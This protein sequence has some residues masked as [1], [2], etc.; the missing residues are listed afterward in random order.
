MGPEMRTTLPASQ[1]EADPITTEVIRGG[2]R[3]AA[4]QMKRAIIRTAFS[5]IVRDLYDFAVAIFDREVRLLA[6]APTVAQFMGTLSFCVEEAVKAVGGEEALEPGDILLYNIPYGT[7]SHSPDAA[8][9]MPVFHSDQLIGYAATKAHW[10]DIGAKESYCTDTTSVFQ[11][12]ILFP[13]VKLYS[14]GELVQDVMRIALANSRFPG[15]VAGD[16]QAQIGGLRT[17]AAGLLRLVERYG[18][19]TFWPCVERMLDHSERLVRSYLEQIPDGRYVGQGV[20][21]NNGLDD[22]PI[23]FEVG[24]EISGS[25]VTV[26]YSNSPEAQRG[27]MNCPRP[28]TVSYTRVAIS[29]LAGGGIPPN[30]GTFR[31]L[32]VVTRPGTMFDP[33]PPAAC[34]MYGWP[35]I[36]AME[37]IFLAVSEAMP[38]AVPASS[39]GDIPV[40]RT[41]GERE[42][43]GKSWVFSTMFQV[44]QGASAHADGSTCIHHSEAGAH[45]ASLELRDALSPWLVEKAEYWV[46]SAGAG[47]HRGGPGVEYHFRILEDTKLTI[48]LEHLKTPPWGLFGGTDARSSQAWIEH[49]DGQR[50]QL[51]KATAKPIPAGSRLIIRTAGGGGYGPPE[52]REVEAVRRDVREGYVS[53]AQARE[54]YPHAF[55]E[56]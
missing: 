17:G 38:E 16:V 8:M 5:Q 10:V 26:D 55:V 56:H 23:P 46:D 39:G 1:V 44:G 7:G 6:E 43:T 2:L 27:P 41:W 24:V 34:F 42:G 13:G 20:L 31:P 36:Q 40:I 30:E 53:A 45:V 51:A 3:S 33:E 28:G 50:E 15:S 35:C 29:M 18:L 4:E 19:D 21:D 37:V 52:E 48:V 9:I 22:D 47:R 54:H 14:R 49:Q 25:D 11:E 12:G 32:S